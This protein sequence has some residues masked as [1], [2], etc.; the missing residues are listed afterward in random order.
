MSS[1]ISGTAPAPA[2]WW[3]G[4]GASSSSRAEPAADTGDLARVGREG[5]L[6]LGFARRGP[7]TVLVERRFT[8][9]L[10]A[11]E[12]V[13][14]DASGA[15]V[16][17]LLN[18]TG[19]LLGGDDL[20]TVVHLGAGSHVC[21]TTP[22]ATRVYRTAGAP[23]R[24]RLT[25]HVGESAT[26]EY[27]PDHLI[28]SPGARL[29]QSTEILLAAT[30]TALLLDAWAVGRLARGEAWEFG[31][32]DIALIA[33]D[34]RGPLLHDRAV[35]DGRP[36]WAEMGGAEGRGYVATLAVLAPARAAWREVEEAL[37]AAL[38]P[39]PAETL[40]GVTRLGRGGVLAR[41][42]APSAPAL[43]HAVR[44][45]WAAARRSLLG[46]PPLDLRKL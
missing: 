38:A 7:R 43:Q 3:A 46:L 1:P 25:A 16:L 29:V 9:P 2:P 27:L 5:R 11:L 24:Q 33:R 18:P 35:L 12:P 13:E 34:G 14:L 39:V 40:H 19:G 23:A 6:R 15:A 31:R 4:S 37:L 20:E 32:L 44:A 17:T 28:P 30:A 22:S 26:L 42:L 36:R 10:Q 8:L 21:L 45:V 41:I